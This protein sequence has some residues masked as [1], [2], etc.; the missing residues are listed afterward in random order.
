MK[1]C[2]YGVVAGLLKRQGLALCVFNF[3]KA[4][5]FYIQ[6]PLY[7]PLWNP[8]TNYVDT[9]LYQTLAFTMHGKI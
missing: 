8:F 3:F 1:G 5:H 4:Y 7:K 6:K 2:K 9:L